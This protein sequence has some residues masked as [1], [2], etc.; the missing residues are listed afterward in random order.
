MFNFPIED[1]FPLIGA[2]GEFFLAEKSFKNSCTLWP[3]VW[4]VLN[5]VAVL[6]Q[7]YRKKMK[8]GIYILWN[9]DTDN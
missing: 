3:S 5:R 2:F 8:C 6:Y 7:L 4:L 1:S 9:A